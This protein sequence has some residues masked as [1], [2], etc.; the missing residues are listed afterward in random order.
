MQLFPTPVVNESY[1]GI[2]NDNQFEEI[3]I[4]AHL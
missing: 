4:R 2:A 1:T 3:N